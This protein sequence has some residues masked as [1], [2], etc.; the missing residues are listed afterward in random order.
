MDC[1]I[2]PIKPLVKAFHSGM[3]NVHNSRIEISDEC[4]MNHIFI[5]AQTK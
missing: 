4:S 2:V 3:P 1:M 5:Y